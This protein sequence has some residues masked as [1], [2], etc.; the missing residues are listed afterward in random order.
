MSFRDQGKSAQAKSVQTKRGRIPTGCAVVFFSLFLAAGAMVI[1]I[2]LILPAY[3][4]FLASGWVTTRCTILSSEVEQH[5]GGDGDTF[6]VNI[7][8]RYHVDGKPY[9]S[10][11]YHFFTGAS[12]G[13]A[14]KQKIV[15]RYPPGS[16]HDA[17]YNPRDPSQAVLHRGFSKDAWFS[18][19]G[20][21][22]FLVGLGGVLGSLGWL[23]FSAKSRTRS[24]PAMSSLAEARPDGASRSVPA[25]EPISAGDADSNDELGIPLAREAPRGPV[26]LQPTDTPLGRCVGALLFGLIWNGILSVFLFHVVR[27]IRQGPLTLFEVFAALFLTPFVLVGVG[28]ILFALHS[29]LAIFSPRPLVTVASNHVALGQALQVQWQFRGDAS[30][31]QRLR[32]V[33]VGKEQATYRR[34]TSTSTDTSVF[35][36]IVAF[37]ETNPTAI[38]AG[39]CAVQV[40]THT[41][42]SL[43][44]GHNK[45][46]WLL[47]VKGEIRF[48]PDVAL[49]FPVEVLP[50]L[51]GWDLGVR[52]VAR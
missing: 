41:M 31:I 30:S 35:A 44:G 47:Q 40:P 12:S 50:H 25:D 23:N 33:L 5:N 16:Q 2:M 26:T 7:R 39:K 52:E 38:A 49:E 8:F 4:I 43:H 28:T 42:H 48:W 34:G 29:F 51:E 13:R 18:L 27:D 32:V 15:A 19:F 21:P 37:D 20:L 24:S 11:R 14:G 22:F 3:R 36:E 6:S 9:E 1:S 10:D 17:Y 45:V 46:L